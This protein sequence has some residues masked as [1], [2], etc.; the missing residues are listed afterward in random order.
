M[1][2]V[3]GYL[4]HQ[5]NPSW[6]AL[7]SSH[8]I[9]Q[10][11]L[12][13]FMRASVFIMDVLVFFPV[14][15]LVAKAAKGSSISLFQSSPSHTS[16]SS[17]AS[18]RSSDSTRLL[19]VLLL[20]PSLILIDYGHFQYNGVSLGLALG[21]ILGLLLDAP[22]VGSSLFTLSLNYK[23]MSLYYAL[24][25]FFVLLGRVFRS[26]HPVTY[27]IK[28]GAT[29]LAVFALC[30]IPFLNLDDALQGCFNDSTRW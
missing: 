27:L 23:Q 4:G 18:T 3:F 24:P 25:F 22:L 14:V 28:V 17:D 15:L 16:K 10:L 1:S 13:I 20:F 29:V 9:E 5:I 11:D 7:G 21:G 30:W 2:F 19:A 12:K 6:M 8:G 26:H